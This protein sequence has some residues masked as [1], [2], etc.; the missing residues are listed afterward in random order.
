MIKRTN[1]FTTKHSV[2]VFQSVL[3]NIFICN[4]L[5]FPLMELQ[6]IYSSTRRNKVDSN[7]KRQVNYYN[8][9]SNINT[10]SE[11]RTRLSAPNNRTLV[12]NKMSVQSRCL[13]WIQ[14]EQIKIFFF[15]SSSVKA[16]SLNR[17]R[18]RSIR[19][20]SCHSYFIL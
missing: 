16:K 7:P 1:P 2:L 10:S 11:N 4:E 12:R 17:S 19:Q 3:L 6:Q 13:R 5:H 15:I 9:T 8:W 18:S 20:L 14:I